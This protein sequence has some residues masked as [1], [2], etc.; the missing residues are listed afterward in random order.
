MRVKTGR[1]I[2]KP[3]QQSSKENGL[4]TRAAAVV[5]VVG[6]REIYFGSVWKRIRG[7]ME[8][9]SNL[10]GGGV[11]SQDYGGGTEASTR[12]ELTKKWLTGEAGCSLDSLSF[13][14]KQL[15]LLHL[16]RR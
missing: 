6:E 9:F 3:V 14:R 7:T 2:R 13:V 5:C 11:L 12:E 1:F 4:C 10:A 15:P 16:G 8:K